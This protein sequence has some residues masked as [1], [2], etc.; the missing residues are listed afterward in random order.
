M[1]KKFVEK[2]IIH[3]DNECLK[4]DLSITKLKFIG[5]R[6]AF[7]LNKIGIYKIKDLLFMFPKKFLSNNLEELKAGEVLLSLVIEKKYKYGR[8]WAID[9]LYAQLV[10]I[11]M[12]FFHQKNLNMF[13][14]NGKYLVYGKLEIY[15]DNWV[16]KNVSIINNQLEN[17]QIPIYSSSISSLVLNKMINEIISKLDDKIIFQPNFPMSNSISHFL[18]D[19]PSNLSMQ[20][21]LFN[22]H[23]N[24]EF[25]KTYN[26]LK[27]IEACLFVALFKTDTIYEPLE[28]IAVGKN[29]T[30]KDI[31]FTNYVQ[32]II[33][34]LNL[35]FT[36]NNDQNCALNDI[37]KKL[38]TN[39]PMKHMLFAEVG[40]GKT[41]ISL[42]VAIFMINLGY[43]VAFLVPTTALLNQHINYLKPFLNLLN[44]NMYCVGNKEQ[45]PEN[46]QFIIGTHALL[47]R[48]KIDKLGLIIIDEMQKFGVL[49]RAFLLDQA[50]RSN[51]LMLSATPIP[52][53]LN[54]LLEEFM[55][56]SQIKESVYR[57]DTITSILFPS[58]IDNLIEKIKQTKKKAYWVL[59]NIDETDFS[60]GA[61]SCYEY[62]M[63]KFDN[64]CS[65]IPSLL[66][67]SH[68][69]IL[70]GRMK[71]QDQIDAIENFKNAEYGVLIAT[72]I[73]EIG[74]DIPDAEIIV[75]E[76][77][78]RFGL[79]QLHQLRGRVGRRGQKSH[80]ILLSEKKYKKLEFFKTHANGLEIA[81]YDLKLRGSG[82]LMGTMQHG[83][84]NNANGFTFLNEHD[85]HLLAYAKILFEQKLYDIHLPVFEL[86]LTLQEIIH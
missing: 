58:Q 48:N 71:T 82:K 66:W 78:E 86:F 74:I 46:A 67:P 72:T 11:T 2:T 79:A 63:K 19:F 44:I 49:Q 24:I 62:I 84:F 17:K 21:I 8:L 14:L 36:L 7:L 32:E 53:S 50:A 20:K 64:D 37:I 39:K 76:S 34:K 59:P 28:K 68:V 22:L 57:K 13:Q 25:E 12:L 81:E 18:S 54:I 26:F 41:I 75:I 56:F 45:I 30:S 73:I 9:C 51:L 6:R 61:I 35:P 27:L 47:Y 15:K 70:H 5:P 60:I 52:R 1:E 42:I 55:S 29:I 23:N 38:S 69:W 40:A 16:I 83:H 65:N 85:S 33:A 10:K 4:L 31:D 80:C 43:N 3:L 77:P